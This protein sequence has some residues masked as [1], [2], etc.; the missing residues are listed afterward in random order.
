MA[1]KFTKLERKYMRPEQLKHRPVCRYGWSNVS[2]DGRTR[3]YRE[4]QEVVQMWKDV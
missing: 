2:D 3:L 4:L 1:V